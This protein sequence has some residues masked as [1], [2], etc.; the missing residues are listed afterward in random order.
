M[1]WNYEGGGWRLITDLRVHLE[2]NKV[3]KIQFKYWDL[4]ECRRVATNL[5]SL[6]DFEDKV[7]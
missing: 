2:K 4:D 7:Y 3:L 6:N 5:E 1:R